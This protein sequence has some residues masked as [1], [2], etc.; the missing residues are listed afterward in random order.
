MK[1]ITVKIFLAA[2]QYEY[3]SY[4][5]TQHTRKKYENMSYCHQ[6]SPTTTP[7]PSLI[8]IIIIIISI[9]HNIMYFTV[10]YLVVIFSIYI[11]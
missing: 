10:Q 8:I 7:C 11:I 4:A 1:S 9:Q 5:S 2:V 3:A 6:S